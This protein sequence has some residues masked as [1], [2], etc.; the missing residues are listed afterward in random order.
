VLPALLLASASPRRAA[1]LASAGVHATVLPVNVDET[2]HT[3]EAP[4]AYARRVALAKAEAGARHKEGGVVL[5][6]DTVVWTRPHEPPLGK[7]R[8]RDDARRMIDRLTSQDAPHFVT[9]AWAV[10][11]RR[12]GAA[13]QPHL[14]Q[15]TTRVWMRGLAASELDAYLD[16]D[17][18]KDKAGGY[19]I[20][21]RA[22]GL[23][24]RIEGSYTNV[25]GLPL[26]QVIEYLRGL[27]T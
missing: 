9:T 2:W 4:V 3:E 7:P 13:A 12:R 16:E 1:L 14:A 8:D 27:E 22:A 15:E 18:W 21:S 10:L 25:V 23:V 24:T 11:D 26:A 20:Q 19:G 17:D 6:A 5:A